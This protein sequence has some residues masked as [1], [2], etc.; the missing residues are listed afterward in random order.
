LG[1]RARGAPRARAHLFL[2]TPAD[3]P[4]GTVAQVVLEALAG[5][6]R[7]LIRQGTW[8]ARWLGGNT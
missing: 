4:P 1:G 6:A 8:D 3:K 5:E 2:A 7:A